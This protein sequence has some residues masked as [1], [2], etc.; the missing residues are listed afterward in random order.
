MF[1][2]ASLKEPKM[3]APVKPVVAVAKPPEKEREENVPRRTF[4]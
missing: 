4:N 1:L 3:E 2:L